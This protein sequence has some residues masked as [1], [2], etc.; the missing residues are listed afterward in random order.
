MSLLNTSPICSPIYMK[1]Q[2]KKQEQIIS[3][4]ALTNPF[5]HYTWYFTMSSTVAVLML[6]TLIQKLWSHASGQ[7]PSSGWLFQGKKNQWIYV[8]LV[9]YGN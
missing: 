2:S 3:F 8:E 5:D 6:L 4:D 9:L 7:N 1:V